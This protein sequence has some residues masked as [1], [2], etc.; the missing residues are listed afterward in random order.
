MER[1]ISVSQSVS[2]SAVLTPLVAPLGTVK[3]IFPLLR[4]GPGTRLGEDSPRNPVLLLFSQRGG[5]KEIFPTY[6]GL[7]PS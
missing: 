7:F 2:E 6:P 1:S 3:S 5:I 4:E